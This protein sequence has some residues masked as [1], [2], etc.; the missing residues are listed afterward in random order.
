LLKLLTPV[1]RFAAVSEE[2][3]RALTDAGMTKA[4]A[5][6]VV[7]NPIDLEDVKATHRLEMPTFTVAYLGNPSHL[8]GF[9]LLPPL[10]HSL[11]R[12]HTHWIVFAGPETLMPD[13]WQELRA[14]PRDVIEIPGKVSD[15]REAYA[16]CNLVI[17]PSFH[18]SF[19][20]VVAEAMAN[21][22]PVVASDIPSLRRLLGDNEAGILVPPGDLDATASAIRELAGDRERRERM[23]RTGRTRV[24]QYD[25]G[26][27]ATSMAQLY[28]ARPTSSTAPG[29]TV[30]GF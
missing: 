29:D 6:T 10:I 25:P 15:V 4:D 8:K 22:L 9:H 3:R 2:T 16:Q 19:G 11:R 14:L 13:V 7:P 12:E 28:G 27:I 18:E 23:G 21:G 20:R 24:K 17:C 1:T 5:V 26:P 30:G